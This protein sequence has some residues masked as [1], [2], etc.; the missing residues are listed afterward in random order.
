MCL[1]VE[2]SG[3]ISVGVG[4]R[5]VRPRA[6]KPVE[7]WPICPLILLTRPRGARCT[8]GDRARLRSV[9]TCRP[10]VLCWIAARDGWVT[11]L[12]VSREGRSRNMVVRPGRNKGLNGLEIRRILD[13]RW[14]CKGG[15]SIAYLGNPELLI[16]F[17]VWEKRYGHV[18]LNRALILELS[19][20]GQL[21]AEGTR[22]DWSVSRRA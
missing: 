17:G 16:A 21:G 13:W 18:L 14:G 5:H 3:P 4:A 15:P 6:I 12:H 19:G 8:G 20:G 10:R 2:K 11:V 1:S 7:C 22:R 9:N